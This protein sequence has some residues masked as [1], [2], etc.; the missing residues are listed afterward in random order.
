MQLVDAP[1]DAILKAV[2]N[3]PQ[4]EICGT[5]NGVFVR[6]VPAWKAFMSVGKIFRTS[7]SSDNYVKI[8]RFL[9]T[10]GEASNADLT[11]LLGYNYSSQ[12]S[13]FLRETNFVERHGNGPS[14]RWRAIDGSNSK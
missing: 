6:V 5:K 8:F 1:L 11:E 10:H 14:A 9:R 3:I 2:S 13:K 4:V 7:P 12:T